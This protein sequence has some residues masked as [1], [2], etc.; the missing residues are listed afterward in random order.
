MIKKI[1][2]IGIGGSGISGVAMLAKAFGFEVSGCDLNVNTPY[3]D[4]LKKSHIEIFEGQDEKHVEDK[5][6]IVVTPA[7]FFQSENHPEVVSAKKQDK[8]IT[9]QEFLGK[10]LQTQKHVICVAGTH[11]KSTTTAMASLLL[12]HAGFDPLVMVGANIK[13]FEGNFR[14]GKSK[15]FVTEADEFYDNFLYYKPQIIIL[16]NIEFDHPDYF[17]DESQIFQ[18][19]EKFVKKLHGNKI[20]IY[21][22]DDDGVKKLFK[23]LGKEYL[24]TINLYGYSLKNANVRLLKSRTEFEVDGKQFVLQIPGEYNVSNA[25]GVITLGRILNIKDDVIKSSL[26]TFNGIGRRLEL[27]GEKNNIKIYDDYAH[28]PTAIRKTLV[29]L[30]Q[31]YDKEKILAI[32]EPHTFSRTKALLPFYKDVFSGIDEVIVAPIFRSRDSEDYGIDGNDIVEI[33]GH[34]NIKYIDGFD[35]IVEYVKERRQK[36]GVIIVMGAGESY[37]LAKD[38]LNNL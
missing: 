21:N 10:Y 23:L 6:L 12:E 22:Q 1:H 8:L 30:R 17:K 4:E 28:H 26:I 3:I 11:G 13:E 24:N 15:Y 16:N 2:F 27:I 35:E 25:L 33:S 34:K 38:I 20:L 7:V 32:I 18:S 36:F 5:D 19:F 37:K 9:W 29:G 14:V 31:K